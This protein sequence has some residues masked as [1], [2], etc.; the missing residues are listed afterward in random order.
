MES[1]ESNGNGEWQSLLEMHTTKTLQGRLQALE[2]RIETLDRLAGELA[3]LRAV[4]SERPA[5]RDDSALLEMMDR[6]DARLA[7]P[8][9]APQQPE[10][11]QPFDVETW[12]AVVRAEVQNAMAQ[13]GPRPASPPGDE[14]QILIAILE[15]L[16][17][18]LPKRDRKRFA[19]RLAQ[20]TEG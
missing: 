3:A 8:A 18:G 13:P 19:E 15:E 20:R 16:I 6:L 7:Q 17:D 14:Q 11:Q 2:E 4:L 9:A 10:P 12:R 5:P 1:F